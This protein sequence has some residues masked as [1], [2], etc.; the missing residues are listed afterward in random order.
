MLSTTKLVLVYYH[1]KK[2][3]PAGQDRKQLSLFFSGK[4]LDW[5]AAS[6]RG[7]FWTLQDRHGK[8]V[9]SGSVFQDLVHHTVNAFLD[10]VCQGIGNLFADEGLCNTDQFYIL[11]TLPEMLFNDQL[12]L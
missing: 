2:V 12:I 7:A 8:S 10:A 3:L 9:F 5:P 1:L 11:K 4:C 6:P